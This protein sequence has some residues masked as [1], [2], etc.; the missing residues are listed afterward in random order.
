MPFEFTP[1]A[2][3]DVVLVTLRPFEDARGFLM[4]TYKASEFAAAGL[5]GR[6]VQDNLSRSSRGVLRGLHFQAP[7]GAQ[8]KLVLCSNGE[9]FDVAVDI[10]RG[11]PTFGKAACAELSAARRSMLWIPPGLA[12][13]FVVLS[14]TADVL[15]KCTAEYDPALDRG[16]LWN[17]PALAIPWPV[18]DPILSEKDRRHPRLAEARLEELEFHQ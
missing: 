2:I 6:F 5:T 7:P 10:R 12:H 18:K 17:D 11:S 13:G 16:I 9:I 3:P 14:E 8:G 4:E 1:L 15:Y